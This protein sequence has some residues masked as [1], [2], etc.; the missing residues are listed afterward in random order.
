[1]MAMDGLYADNAGAVVGDGHGWPVCRQRRSSCRRVMSC[2]SLPVRDRCRVRRW[3][4]AG[5]THRRGTWLEIRCSRTHRG[6]RA[7]RSN[8]LRRNHRPRRRNWRQ[9]RIGIHPR[10]GRRLRIHGW[11][12][13]PG[14]R[15]RRLHRVA[16][17]Q[18]TARGAIALNALAAQDARLIMRLQRLPPDRRVAVAPPGIW[19][20]IAMT[21]TAIE[22]PMVADITRRV[23]VDISGRRTVVI[24]ATAFMTVVIAAGRRAAG[25][26]QRGKQG[27]CVSLHD[28]SGFWQVHIFL[29]HAP[30][31][32]QIQA[33]RAA[34]SRPRRHARGCARGCRSRRRTSQP[35]PA[36]ASA[37]HACARA[38]SA[39]SVATRQRPWSIAP[40]PGA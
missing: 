15:S 25:Q 2:D 9:A 23:D 29:Q 30:G 34:A 26:Q 17:S 21:E 19:I 33:L 31:H 3:R 27:H 32:R 6:S 14:C 10:R 5:R 1:M 38:K 22:A 16:A 18:R 8:R 24:V 35:P 13:Q 40:Q 39:D 28:S 12:L 4:R 11:R 20:A 37:V 36:S 7:R